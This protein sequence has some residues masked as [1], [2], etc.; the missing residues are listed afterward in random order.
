MSN[1][2]E[3]EERKKLATRAAADPASEYASMINQPMRV[4]D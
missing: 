2:Q 1:N 3:A 4:A